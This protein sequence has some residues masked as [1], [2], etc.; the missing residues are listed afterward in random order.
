MALPFLGP[1]GQMHEMGTLV[2]NGRILARLRPLGI[3]LV[4]IAASGCGQ[5]PCSI[6]QRSSIERLDAKWWPA[7]KEWATADPMCGGRPLL[8][9]AIADEFSP[10]KVRYLLDKGVAVPP[11]ARVYALAASANTGEY[12]DV[13]LDRH[14]AADLG[15]V[16]NFCRTSDSQGC[17]RLVARL[18]SVAVLAQFQFSVRIRGDEG[19]EWVPGFLRANF[20]PLTS[21]V[22]CNL[23]TEAYRAGDPVIFRDV[24]VA[25]ASRMENR[26]DA[27]CIALATELLRSD[28]PT[29]TWRL[30]TDAMTTGWGNA[31][32][33]EWLLLA[34][35]AKRGEWEVLADLVTKGAVP[36]PPTDDDVEYLNW[37]TLDRIESY[38]LSTPL[39]IAVEAGDSEVTDLLLGAGARPFFDSL[40]AAVTSGDLDTVKKIMSANTGTLFV[41]QV[42]Y[43][44]GPD[45]E[46]GPQ[47]FPTRLISGNFISIAR[48]L[49]HTAIERYLEPLAY[50]PSNLMPPL[51]AAAGAGDVERFNKEMAATGGPSSAICD[52][53]VVID[54]CKVYVDAL[55]AAIQ[56]RRGDYLEIVRRIID[57]D[58]GSS[59]RAVWGHVAYE[60][61][62]LDDVG[63]LRILLQRAGD[64]DRLHPQ[65]VATAYS[66]LSL[67]AMEYLLEMGASLEVAVQKE[68][69]PPGDDD[70][71]PRIIQVRINE[72]D[73]WHDV[74]RNGPPTRGGVRVIDSPY[75]KATVGQT[76]LGWHQMD[77]HEQAR[78]KERLIDLLAENGVACGPFNPAQADWIV[79]LEDDDR[80]PPTADHKAILDDLAHY[81]FEKCSAVSRVDQVVAKARHVWRRLKARSRALMIDVT[82]APAG[83]DAAFVTPH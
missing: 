5:A 34:Q 43:G 27:A 80:E 20:D 4:A 10:A 29:A 25:V 67:H 35:L 61:V 18:P 53:V 58:L 36:N 14:V 73:L 1:S 11:A 60:A 75:A 26:A 64:P 74:R 44:P 55:E 56:S 23:M 63:V 62:L 8:E 24:A 2:G 40:F 33:H 68:I 17:R 30:L 42:V 77:D 15:N 39:A 31:P 71:Q 83:G 12:V 70:G 13:L 32:D 46:W 7:L 6:L 78:L 69:E 59:R 50:Y 81:A 47:L 37:P 82:G 65:L 21:S 16:W 22:G 52:F 45:G 41:T 79:F 9:H 54:P 48:I 19:S 28:S 72:G 51:V 57:A 3:L 49:G 76:W 66:V 38:Q